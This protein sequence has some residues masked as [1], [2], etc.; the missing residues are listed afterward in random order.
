[1]L[2]NIFLIGILS[3]IFLNIGCKNKEK[4]AA[5][6]TAQAKIAPDK[7]GR[8]K[9]PR[10]IIV[11]IERTGCMG[12]CPA[13][14]ATIWNDGVAEYDGK[15]YVDKMGKHTASVSA[16]QIAAI[17]KVAADCKYLAFAEKL[18]AEPQKPVP[19][20]IPGL[21]I[22]YNSGEKEAYCAL[23]GIDASQ[24]TSLIKTSEAVFDKL[25]WTSIVEGK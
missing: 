24:I 5:T 19:S 20:D 11:E 7:P 15:R 13:F 16:E 6:T 22:Y 8:G 14:K 17:N 23:K 1:M 25:K 2:K 10:Y 18:A 12:K 21:N 4:A 9:G 3:S